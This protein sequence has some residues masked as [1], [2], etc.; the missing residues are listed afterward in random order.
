MNIMMMIIASITIKNSL[1]PLIEGLCAQ[2]YYFKLEII[3]GFAFPFAF[4]FRTKKCV[5]EKVVSPRSHPAS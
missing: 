5:E 3:G 1:A 4:L 2:I